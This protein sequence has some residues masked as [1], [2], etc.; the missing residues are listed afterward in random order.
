M[1][2]LRR[3]D[4]PVLP[5]TTNFDIP[6]RFSHTI[7]GQSFIV[8]DRVSCW[9]K[10]KRMIVFGTDQQLSFL[11]KCSHIMIDGTYKSCPKFFKQV[12]SIHG[13]KYHQSM[14]AYVVFV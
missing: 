3:Q 14:F 8:A 11:F 13:M 7:D 4:F 1:N 9:D 10:K 2:I 12:F 6:K 5:T